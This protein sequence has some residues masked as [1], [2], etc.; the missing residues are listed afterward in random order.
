MTSV[1]AERPSAERRLPSAGRLER[2]VLLVCAWSGPAIIV[3]AFA[4]WLVAGVLPFPLGPEDSERAVVDFYSGGL[5]V[6]LGIGLASLGVSLLAP[7]V[8]GLSH[9]MRTST[10]G[11]SLLAQVQLVTGSVTAVLL[12]VPMLLMAIIAFRPDRGG[13]LTVMLNDVAWLLFLTPI[14]PFILQNLAVAASALLD[15]RSPFPRWVGY[16]NCWIA[17]TF[18]FDVLALAIHTGPFRWNGVLI[19]WLALTTYSVF[20]LVMGFLLR[21]LAL[22][23]PRPEEGAR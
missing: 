6:V 5:H 1:E 23:G 22:A 11:S 3:V 16:L 19:F 13:D 4:G 7:L 9:V 17:F 10:A 8:A 12:F 21:N 15:P 2:Q 18:S 20:L 14:I